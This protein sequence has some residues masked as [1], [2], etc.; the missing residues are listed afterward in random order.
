MV[1]VLMVVSLAVALYM[2]VNQKVSTVAFIAL[3]CLICCCCNSREGF[4]GQLG[5]F[6]GVLGEKKVNRTNNVAR[7]SA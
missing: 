3:L 6:Q 5:Q 1:N 7:R 4:E 2:F